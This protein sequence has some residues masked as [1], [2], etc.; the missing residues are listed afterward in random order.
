VILA[1]AGGLPV[2][3]TIAQLVPAG[4][5]LLVT[6]HLVAGRMRRRTARFIARI[7]GGSL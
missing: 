1:H 2:E 7:C 3:E 4:I 6:L 5:A